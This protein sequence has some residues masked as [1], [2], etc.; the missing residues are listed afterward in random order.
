[1][2]KLFNKKNNKEI[3]ENNPKG[4]SSGFVLLFSIILASI[5]F[6]IAIGV[7]SISYK[8]ILLTT[9]AKNS[10]DAFFAA[11]VGIECALYLDKD[12]AS[13]PFVPGSSNDNFSTSTDCAGL[14]VS[15]I[16]STGSGAISFN[17]FN[18][19]STSNSCAIVS[20][21]KDVVANPQTM[22]I[23]SKG[24]NSGREPDCPSGNNIVERQLQ[25]SY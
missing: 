12:A 10:N 3:I 23:I 11:D 18:L 17:L 24:Y 8:E 25:A 6:A 2:K 16:S 4:F 19:D 13:S 7:S 20:V 9:S 22:T 5:I 14:T 1:M 21:V 15:P